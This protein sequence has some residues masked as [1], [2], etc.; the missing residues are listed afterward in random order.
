MLDDRGGVGLLGFRAS[1]LAAASVLAFLGKEVTPR[2]LKSTLRGT[3]TE[4]TVDSAILRDSFTGTS[5]TAE[6]A[7]TVVAAAVAATDA[8]ATSV[9]GIASRSPAAGAGGPAALVDVE[10][11]LF[12]VT[13]AL[14]AR[15]RR[16]RADGGF[17]GNCCRADEDGTAD[18][19]TASDAG[20]G[21]EATSA[22]ALGAALVVDTG[23]FTR[24]GTVTF[25]WIGLWVVSLL[26]GLSKAS[27]ATSPGMSEFAKLSEVDVAMGTA[28]AGA[29]AGAVGGASDSGTGPGALGGAVVRG[30]VLAGSAAV[31]VAVD[32]IV[33]SGSAVSSAV[34]CKRR[35]VLKRG[36]G[37]IA[38]SEAKAL[39]LLV[40]V[41]R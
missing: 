36:S 13:A 5:F 34:R 8:S 6:T 17:D 14:T 25:T 32:T 39:R 23:A 35:K 40:V 15:R 1:I 7:P 22:G 31:A 33:G 26:N 27:E 16:I 11:V 29:R 4:G 3:G 37:P 18:G 41:F 28:T 9:A 2:L 24:G 12:G 19:S 30:G 21:V 20:I 10:E 38:T